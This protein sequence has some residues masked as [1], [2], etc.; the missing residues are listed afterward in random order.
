MKELRQASQAESYDKWVSEKYLGRSQYTREHLQ[1]RVGHCMA[2]PLRVIVESGRSF[3]EFTFETNKVY[4]LAWDTEHILICSSKK[5]HGYGSLKLWIRR[6]NS[7]KGKKAS[8]F[9]S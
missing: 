1:K 9:K 7:Y 4:R 2:F 8:N 6:P 5:N 3:D